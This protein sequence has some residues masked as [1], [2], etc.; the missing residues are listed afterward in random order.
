M[1]FVSISIQSYIKIHL[2]NNPTED[3]STLTRNLKRALSDFQSGVK[4]SCGN[5]IWVI[6]S[7]QI[8]NTCFTCLTGESMPTD[9]YEIDAALPKSQPKEGRRHIDDMDPTMIS[10]FFDDDG[11]EINMNLVKK[12][13][14]CLTCIHENNPHEELLCQM[15]RYDQKDNAEFICGAYRRRE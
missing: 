6:G 12:P 4:C 9:H 1:G 8:G 3:K 2:R 13:G 10:G 15:N 7:S 11:Y 5:D 14:L